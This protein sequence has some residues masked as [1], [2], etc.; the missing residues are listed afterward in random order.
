MHQVLFY[1]R[2]SGILTCFEMCAAIWTVGQ[3]T[4]FEIGKND[5]YLRW[6]LKTT[7]NYFHN[8]EIKRILIIKSIFCAWRKCKT[9]IYISAAKAL[10]MSERAMKICYWRKLLHCCIHPHKCRK[11]G[12]VRMNC[13]FCRFL[14]EAQYI[15]ISASLGTTAFK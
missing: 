6:L 11:T 5:R 8:K 2:A 3:P 4:V 15:C 14:W 1:V 13:V 9:A 12:E 7:Y 10:L